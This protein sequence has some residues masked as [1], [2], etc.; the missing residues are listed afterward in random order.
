L[1]TIHAAKGLEF[2]YV[3]VVGLEENLFPSQMSLNS[4]SDL[5][6]ERRLFYVAVTRAEKQ[7]T[8][9]YA[10]TRYRFGNIIYCEP[11]RFIDEIDDKFMDYPEEPQAP[12]FGDNFFN[13]FRNEY[14]ETAKKTGEGGE[15]K[16]PMHFN[17][18]AKKLI[19]LKARTFTSSASP[20]DI[21]VNRSL[22]E[23]D[24]VLH[25]K[26]GKGRIVSLEGNWP[27]T[28]AL[29]QFE[30]AGNKNLLLKFA[31]LNKI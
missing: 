17:P 13:R 19:S 30:N 15:V 9:S 2:K 14:N 11:S 28:K 27:E 29:I 25:E 3:Y 1:M 6:E 5:E 20:V 18:P 8:L 21:E 22:R 26:F 16:N 12:A 4:R 10:T 23:D 31:R 7:A 24:L